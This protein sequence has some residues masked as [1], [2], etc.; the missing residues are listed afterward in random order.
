MSP[1]KI[2]SIQLQL[3]MEWNPVKSARPPTTPSW[4]KNLYAD[5]VQ[6]QHHVT[7]HRQLHS[8]WDQRPCPST[9]KIKIIALPERQY[10]VWIEGSILGSLSTFQ[11]KNDIITY[12]IAYSDLPRITMS[13]LGILLCGVSYWVWWSM[14]CVKLKWIGSGKLS[15]T[16]WFTK[17]SVLN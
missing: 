6:Q 16:I 1:L 11:Q 14:L 15:Q 12:H 13:S 4:R 2:A 5:T 8:E 7:R 9:I 17:S 10:S 3:G